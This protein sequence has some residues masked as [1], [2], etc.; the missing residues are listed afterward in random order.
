[1]TTYEQNFATANI[2]FLPQAASGI[3]ISSLSLFQDTLFAGVTWP[4]NQRPTNAAGILKYEMGA[5]TYHKVTGS[6]PGERA[7]ANENMFWQMG[8]PAMAVFKRK[9]D[10]A[11]ALYASLLTLSGCELLMTRDGE[12]VE[13]L[14]LIADGVL[15]HLMVAFNDSLFIATNDKQ[16]GPVVYF[17]ADP[18]A[19]EWKQ[20]TEAGF[21]D[22]SNIAI[23][24]MAEFN[25]SLYVATL[26]PSSG[27]Q[28][29]Y[30]STVNDDPVWRQVISQGAHRY[31]LNPAVISMVVYEGALYLGT[32]PNGANGEEGDNDSAGAELIRVFPD[33]SWEIVVGSPR[34]SPVG[35]KVPM[36]AMGPGFDNRKNNAITAMAV[37]EGQLYAST[38][39]TGYINKPQMSSYRLWSTA[40]G[41]EWLAVP[42]SSTNSIK[43][44]TVSA[45]ISTPE[46]LLL[47]TSEARYQHLFPATAIKS[48]GGKMAKEPSLIQ[49]AKSFLHKY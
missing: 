35:L 41:D 43:A 12:N 40:D 26:N 19:G 28:L 23:T 5:D 31:T 14:P 36:A 39:D 24:S 20:A 44:M 18:V 17:S 33:N 13:S 3:Q 4:A 27:F 8:C 42:I 32:G 47:V 10:A 16:R 45:M 30:T 2:K 11:A 38:S 29:W 1:M 46:N 34:F 15:A 37:H 9:A 7:A 49:R 48:N 21:G 6:E 22:I 25:G